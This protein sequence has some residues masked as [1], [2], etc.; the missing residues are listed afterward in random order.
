MVMTDLPACRKKSEVHGDDLGG[1]A[2]A[3]D[4]LDQR[5]QVRRV[6]RVPDHGPLGVG[7]LVLHLAHPVARRRRR[8]HDALGGRGVDV[9]EQRALELE[10]LRRAL[11]DEVRLRAGRGQVVLDG[12]V[13]DARALGQAELGQRRPAASTRWRSRVSA[14]SAGSQATTR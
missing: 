4:D 6:E 5:D 14:S 10:V 13:V 11:L 8:D 2:R 9:G 7:A 1:G 12:E 3:A